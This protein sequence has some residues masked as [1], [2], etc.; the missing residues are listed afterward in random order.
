VY[1]NDV[2]PALWLW[3]SPVLNGSLP[4]LPHK[5]L[6]APVTMEEAERSHILQT[7]PQIGGAVCG[8]NRAAIRLGLPRTTLIAKM[9]RLGINRE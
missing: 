9:Q 4:K 7:L 1:G 3:A 6:S 2:R 5:R 8:P